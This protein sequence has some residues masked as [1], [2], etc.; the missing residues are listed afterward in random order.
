VPNNGSYTVTLPD[1][2]ATTATCRFMVKAVGNVF[3]AVNSKNFTINNL[4]ASAD[5]FGGL[6]NFNLYPN[7][8]NGQ[9]TL[10]FD[11]ATTSD[12]EVLVHDMRGREV[13]KKS[14]ANTGMFEQTLNL[15]GAQAGMYLVTVKDG[16]NKEVKK[17]V[18]E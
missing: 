18:V 2:A 12:I 13:Y 8:N 5:S 15:G 6:K 7:P 9:F 14:F 3:L 10:S 16:N 17:I 4:V 11:S 1:V